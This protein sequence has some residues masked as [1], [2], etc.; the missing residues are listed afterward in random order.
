MLEKDEEIVPL[1]TEFQV[2][3]A[4]AEDG[5]KVEETVSASTVY[6]GRRIGG[7]DVVGGGSK[8]ALTIANDGEVIAILLDWPK[9]ERTKEYQRTLS[10]DKIAERLS[11]YGNMVKNTDNIKL[12]RFECGYYDRGAKNFDPY[13]YIQ[14][15]CVAYTIGIKTS[16]ANY[17]DGNSNI[18]EM[19][20][21]VINSIPAGADVEWDDHWP[22]TW[23]IID[24]GDFCY[25][26]V[27]SE[28]FNDIAYTD[29][30][31]LW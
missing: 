5:H 15:G 7:V 2:E 11:A 25:E 13:G 30:G 18:D 1:W 14:A 4:M 20:F 8:I 21:P 16:V 27:F 6:F 17:A 10:V 26:S 24:G 19:M 22:E 29:P 3:G 31:A 23:S 9:Y 12:D 28:C